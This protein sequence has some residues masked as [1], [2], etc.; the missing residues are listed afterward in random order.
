VLKLK[1][2][3]LLAKNSHWTLKAI[4][5]LTFKHGLFMY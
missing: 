5:M 2:V 3:Q 1:L 4:K